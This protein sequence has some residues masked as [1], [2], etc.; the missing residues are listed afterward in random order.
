MGVTFTPEGKESSEDVED[1]DE[2]EDEEVEGVAEKEEERG[3]VA[4]EELELLS[5]EKMEAAATATRLPL[6]DRV[7]NRLSV[8]RVALVPPVSVDPPLVLVLA[9][10]ARDPSRWRPNLSSSSPFASARNLFQS[11]MSKSIEV[12]MRG[13]PLRFG[14]NKLCLSSSSSL[15][16]SFLSSLLVQ[17]LWHSA[18]PPPR[19]VQP[20]RATAL[21]QALLVGSPL[22]VALSCLLSS[23]HQTAVS[24]G[25]TRG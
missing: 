3:E 16:V 18:P 17:Y 10:I 11:Q 13:R 9:L 20:A 2:D 24:S 19:L 8:F 21:L 12:V 5:V 15:L 14:P 23:D 22:R 4:V 25:V 1:D 7:P 6:P